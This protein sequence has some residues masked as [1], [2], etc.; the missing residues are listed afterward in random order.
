MTWRSSHSTGLSAAMPFLL[1][2]LAATGT[3]CSSAA[4][5]ADRRK[6]RPTTGMTTSELSDCGCF[7][8]SRQ[9]NFSSGLTPIDSGR[10]VE[11]VSIL[12]YLCPMGSTGLARVVVVNGIARDV[13][14]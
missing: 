9:R 5:E 10:E 2:L 8:A 14:E 13:Q 3:G 11:S 1:V 4:K 7:S 6:C 12:S